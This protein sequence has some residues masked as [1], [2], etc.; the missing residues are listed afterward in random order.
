[1]LYLILESCIEIERG[2]S[3]P[4]GCARASSFTIATFQQRK[5]DLRENLVKALTEMIESN[6]N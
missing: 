6:G 1:M 4:R 3:L 5:L 2:L